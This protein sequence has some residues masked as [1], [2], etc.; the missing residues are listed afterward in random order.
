MANFLR[1]KK[2]FSNS[3]LFLL[4]M[5][6]LT[7]WG[8]ISLQ[9]Q[10]LRLSNRSKQMDDFFAGQESQ[11]QSLSLSRRLPSVG[12]NNIV[13]DWIYLNFIQYFGDTLIREKKGYELCP[14]YFKSLIKKD[15]A[16]VDAVLILDICTSVFDGQPLKSLDNLLISV[17]SMNPH[18]I[19]INTRPYYVW[20]A[21]GTGQLLFTDDPLK[22]VQSYRQ[23][24]DWAKVYS[25]EPAQRFIQNLSSSIEFLSKNPDSK[26]ARIG[27]WANILGTNPDK[28]TLTRVIKEIELLGGKVETTGEGRFSVKLRE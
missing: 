4:I 14:D 1:L 9:N 6:A 16:F 13:A 10:E 8:V 22:T 27:A 25:D 2:T 19:S 21:L 20:K 26:L 28:K 12:F 11:K 5:F 7:L 15:P 17:N 18:M 3:Q 24:I 23:A